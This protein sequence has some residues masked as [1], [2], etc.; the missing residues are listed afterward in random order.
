MLDKTKT[1]SIIARQNKAKR[2]SPKMNE[3]VKLKRCPMKTILRRKEPYKMLERTPKPL[4]RRVLIEEGLDKSS[5]KQH[6]NNTDK[7]HLCK[8]GSF[9][10]W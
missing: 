10:I 4:S 2:E 5:K 7:W 9:F 6:S 8:A 3:P 1:L